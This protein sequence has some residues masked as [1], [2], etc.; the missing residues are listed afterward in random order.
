M[1][2]CLAQPP[3]PIKK[4]EQLKTFT[5]QGHKLNIWPFQYTVTEQ[6]NSPPSASGW[7]IS[8]ILLAV[9]D[10]VFSL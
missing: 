2:F 6:H 8:L 7:S 4:I 3:Q 10:T 9:R 5:G 1:P